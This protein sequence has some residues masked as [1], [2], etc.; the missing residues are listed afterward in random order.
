MPLP[1]GDP[2]STGRGEAT[3]EGSAHLPTCSALAV[4]RSVL[5]PPPQSGWPRPTLTP[6]CT[7]RRPSCTGGCHSRGL[8]GGGGDGGEGGGQTGSRARSLPAPGSARPGNGLRARTPRPPPPPPTVSVT[9]P[10]AAGAAAAAWRRAAVA[11]VAAARVM[12]G[13]PSQAGYVQYPLTIDAAARAEER[14]GR[15]GAARTD[16]RQ[17]RLAS[18]KGQTQEAAPRHWP[19]PLLAPLPGIYIAATA[20]VARNCGRRPR[21][22]AVATAVSAAAVHES[23]RRYAPRGVLP[24][25][26][27]K[28]GQGGGGLPR[29][30]NAPPPRP[31][32][33]RPR[34][35][36]ESRRRQ[37]ARGGPVGQRRKRAGGVVVAGGRGGTETERRHRGTGAEGEGGGGGVRELLPP[38]TGTQRGSARRRPG[39]T[40]NR[41]C[42]AHRWWTIAAPPPDTKTATATAH[43][44]RA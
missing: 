39:T 25:S 37:P 20:A 43:C 16:S 26:C 42:H 34:V 23:R 31:V 33:A 11:R 30:P 40:L 14:V 2:A 28:W 15:G 44:A 1:R 3:P 41:C 27:Q 6:L 36:R 12:G 19:P 38:P 29:T 13:R 32:S 24:P 22:S 10:P 18:H 7:A 21:R 35:G 17:E 5:P 9:T 4:R 8:R